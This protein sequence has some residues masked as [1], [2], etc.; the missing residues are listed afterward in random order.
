VRRTHLGV[1][2]A[3]VLAMVALVSWP[4][5]R[6]MRAQSVWRYVPDSVLLARTQDAARFAGDRS[7]FNRTDFPRVAGQPADPGYVA[8][9]LAQVGD[10]LNGLTGRALTSLNAPIPYARLV[11]R[12]IRTGQVLARTTANADGEFSF[13]DLDRNFYIVEVIGAND[14]V[15]GTSMIVGA[16]TRGELRSIEVRVASAAAAVR[17]AVGNILTATAPEAAAVA[18]ANDVTRTT[19]TQA[20]AVSPGA[21]T[22]SKR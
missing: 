16:M 7:L 11:L 13:G 20:I 17:T 6:P 18:A 21:S 15:L 22:G 10:R 5:F 14:A 4:E 3:I 8:K 19:T 9:D 1:Q 2:A 12:N